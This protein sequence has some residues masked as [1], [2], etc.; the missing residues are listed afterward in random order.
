MLYEE[1]IFMSC[2]VGGVT[3]SLPRYICVT[4]FAL[5]NMTTLETT[6]MTKRVTDSSLY[7]S[8]PRLQIQKSAM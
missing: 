6:L 1:D 5:S 3:S 4:G 7:M 2:P 8:C